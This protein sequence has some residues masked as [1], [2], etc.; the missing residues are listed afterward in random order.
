MQ[1][2]DENAHEREVQIHVGEVFEITLPENPTTGFRW[3][4]EASGES[5]CSLLDDH[6]E[7]SPQN[8]PGQGGRHYWHFKAVQVGSGDITLVYRRSWEQ[9]GTP[10][11][12][13]T[14]RVH[15]VA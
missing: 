7:A 10:A 6:F 4:F 1:I 14:L 13:F 12:K 8:L 11:R 5:F 2:F 15:M 3:H 9:T